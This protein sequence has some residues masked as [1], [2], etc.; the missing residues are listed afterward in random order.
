MII[1]RQYGLLGYMRIFKHESFVFETG[2]VENEVQP[3]MLNPWPEL[4]AFGDKLDLRNDTETIP[5]ALILMKN[6]QI[7][8]EK[9]K[10]NLPSCLQEEL[11]FT[12]LINSARSDNTYKGMNFDQAIENQHLI[13]K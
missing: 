9:N 8:K 2:K 1:L 4:K 6:I 10:G 13:Y 5:W 7:W 11:Q 3:E 12:D